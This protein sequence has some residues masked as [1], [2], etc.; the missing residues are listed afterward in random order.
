[1]SVRYRTI[2]RQ[3]CRKSR[4]VKQRPF[5]WLRRTYEKRWTDTRL[6]SSSRGDFNLPRTNLH[7]SDK[8]FSVARPQAWNSLPTGVHSAVTKTIFCKH[9]KTHLF[10]VKSAMDMLVSFI[11]FF[12]DFIRLLV[13]HQ[14]SSVTGALANV[15]DW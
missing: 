15:I 7:L 9:L 1:L 13:R 5:C 10:R 2:V 11:G 6:R 8:A 4:P 12:L 3:L 14:R